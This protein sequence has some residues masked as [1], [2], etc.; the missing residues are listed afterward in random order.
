MTIMQRMDR[1]EN[2]RFVLRERIQQRRDE[3]ITRQTA[4]E[5]EMKF[6]E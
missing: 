1:L 3:H 4:H 5:I 2:A 6:Q